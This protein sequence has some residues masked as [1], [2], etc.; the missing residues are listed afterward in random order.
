MRL[1]LDKNE[2]PAYWRESYEERAAIIEFMANRPRA[3][4]ERI[5]ESA[6]R[7]MAEDSCLELIQ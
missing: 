3:E 6:I 4:A 5:A 2:W 7:K 1:P